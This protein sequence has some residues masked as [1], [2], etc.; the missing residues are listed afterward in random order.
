MKFEF[1]IKSTCANWQK[2]AEKL[3]RAAVKEAGENWIDAE[4][5][6]HLPE[7][8]RCMTKDKGFIN[9]QSHG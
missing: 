7:R 2:T 9:L 4:I 3:A 8:G 6:I 1:T 5:F